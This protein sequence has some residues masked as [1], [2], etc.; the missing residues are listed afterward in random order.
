LTKYKDKYK[1]WEILENTK[2]WIAAADVVMFSVFGGAVQ[3]WLL[4]G[5]VTIPHFVL[6]RLCHPYA[7]TRTDDDED[8]D[9]ASLRKNLPEINNNDLLMLQLVTEMSLITIELMYHYGALGEHSATTLTYLCLAVSISIDAYAASTGFYYHPPKLYY[10]LTGKGGGEKGAM[11]RMKGE[12]KGTI[13]TLR[14]KSESGKLR[15]ENID[16]AKRMIDK[17]EKGEKV[18]INTVKLDERLISHARKELANAGE[19]LKITE[20]NTN[21]LKEAVTPLKEKAENGTLEEGDIKKAR[22]VIKELKARAQVVNDITVKVDDESIAKADKA[23]HDAEQVLAPKKDMTDKLDEVQKSLAKK[24]REGALEEGDIK[25]ARR[26]IEKVKLGVKVN[27]TPLMLDYKSIATA[28]EALRHAEEEL[29]KKAMKENIEEKAMKPL[30]EKSADGSIAQEDIDGARKVIDGVMAG[31]K[32]KGTIVTLDYKSIA[33]AEKALRVAE[34]VLVQKKELTEKL[35]KV[36]VSLA[37]KSRDGALEEGDIKEARRVI[38]EVKA[39]GKV[40]D[41]TVKLGDKSIAEAEE[42]LRRAEEELA[43]KKVMKE[44]IEEKA[45]KPLQEK[46]ADGSIAQEDIDGARKVIDGVKAGSKVNGTTVKVDD[47]SIAEAEKALRDAE[48]VLAQKKDMTEKLEKALKPLREKSANGSIAQED[49]DEAREVIVEGVNARSKVNG[50][51]VKVDDE[52]IAEA[53]DALRD[54]EQVLVQKKELTDKLDEVEETLAKKSR[55]GALEEGDIKKARGVIEEVKAGGKVNDITVKLGD[56]LTARAEE[57]LRRAEEELAQKKVMKENIEEKAMKPLQEKSADGSIAQEDIDGARKVID[58]VKA[59]SK[60]N[61]TTVMLDYKSIAE[62]E[63]ALRDAEQVLAQKENSQEDN[64]NTEPDA[65]SD[66]TSTAYS[67]DFEE[68]EGS[69]D[70]GDNGDGRANS[71][72]GTDESGYSDDSADY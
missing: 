66:E 48:A 37:E 25:E 30:Q 32:V 68:G 42:A 65:A 22:A 29:A 43:Q 70:G 3:A 39:G 9:N 41:I 55:D 64:S 60:V 2:K 69:N 40:N 71:G 28:E 24:S 67:E 49:I 58:G 15:Q 26:V 4:L 10:T 1:W 7:P 13:D 16:R 62:A 18:I 8:E 47:E 34:Q 17:L 50:T 51:R 44:N 21:D 11:E 20:Q 57:A 59:G 61:G 53:E 12:L 56:K 6:I 36:E 27:G 38:E 31:S 23:L 72:D 52:S 14:E 5:V 46:S 45:M 33:E 35:D 19:V 54:A 63:K